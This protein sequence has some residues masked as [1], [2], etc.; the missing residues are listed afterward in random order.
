M[1][2]PC[3]NTIKPEN[4]FRF[5][6]RS[7]YVPKLSQHHQH[8]QIDHQGRDVIIVCQMQVLGRL[9][10]TLVLKGLRKTTKPWL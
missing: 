10:T 5:A 6:G 3:P 9:L 7:N 8:Q 2:C 1:L 4:S